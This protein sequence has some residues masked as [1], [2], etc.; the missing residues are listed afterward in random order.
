M[1]PR[2]VKS[3]AVATSSTRYLGMKEIEEDLA[4]DGRGGTSPMIPVASVSVG[5][6]PTALIAM[7][8]A[9]TMAFPTFI[10][11]IKD[12]AAR[13]RAEGAHK[14]YEKTLAKL[15]E[16]QRA[17]DSAHASHAEAARE[18]ETAWRELV[19]VGVPAEVKEKMLQ[20]PPPSTS[21]AATSEPKPKKPRR[22]PKTK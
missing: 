17:L 6:D 7:G 16:A 12:R 11:E 10:R 19:L 18:H 3:M 14:R 15:K 4:R 20:L 8:V 2:A 21:A 22:K 13:R 5:F 9:A 1:P